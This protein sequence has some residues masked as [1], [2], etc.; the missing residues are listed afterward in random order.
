MKPTTIGV[1][2]NRVRDLTAEIW[3]GRRL[4]QEAAP[5]KLGVDRALAFSEI[6]Q[7]LYQLLNGLD[8]IYFAQGEYAYADEIVF[9]ALEKLRKGSRQNLQAP[10]SVIDWR[11]IVH[12]MRLFKSAEELAVMRRAGRDH[13]AGPYP[14]DGKMPPWHV[15]ISA[16]R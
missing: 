1:L 14:G 5:A 7:Q 15:R 16:G 8:A 9:N 11:P 4:G 13:R 12:E 6:N 2:F 3:F 10:N